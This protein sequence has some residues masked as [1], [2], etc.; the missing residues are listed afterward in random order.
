MPSL[1]EKRIPLAGS[2]KK[3]LP[4]AQIS[5]TAPHGEFQVTVM[6]RRRTALPPVDAH[7]KLKLAERTYINRQML[8]ATYG[9]DPADLDKVAD[10]ARNNNLKVVERDAAKR[11][12]ILSATA[13]D[14]NLAFGVDLKMYRA[15]D[16]LYRGREGE[17]HIPESLREIVT[18]VTGLDDRPF[19]R[20]HFRIRRGP[21]PA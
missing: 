6:V 18:S 14:Y 9:A 8:A 17:I 1:Q 15:H 7:A 21:A 12:V 4:N 19:A 3:R 16:T 10:F 20:P 13:S 11:H 2:N 5:G